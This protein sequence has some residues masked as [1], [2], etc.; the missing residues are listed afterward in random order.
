MQT[1]PIPLT[2]AEANHRR[3]NKEVVDQMHLH[4]ALD[5][6]LVDWLLDEYQGLQCPTT[7]DRWLR[8]G[9]T[10]AQLQ[11]SHP[12]WVIPPL[13][14]LPN[15]GIYQSFVP[16]TETAPRGSFEA[17]VRGW[18]ARF[19][20]EGLTWQDADDRRNDIR[21]TLHER[22]G[23][24]D[25]GTSVRWAAIARNHPDS[26]TSK[27]ARRERSV[28]K[29]VES[30]DAGY[31]L[32]CCAPREWADCV[33]LESWLSVAMDES[34]QQFAKSLTN[35]S[36]SAVLQNPRRR[37]LLAFF[38][39]TPG[40]TVGDFATQTGRDKTQVSAELRQ[41]LRAMVGKK[42]ADL[43]RHLRADRLLAALPTPVRDSLAQLVQS[44]PSAPT[45]ASVSA[46]TSAA[47]SA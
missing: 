38:M 33:T 12:A 35:S 39:N 16:P 20:G 5:P 4:L 21:Q 41:V 18:S 7:L 10:T 37:A 31:D 22:W 1:C 9:S 27:M 24:Y 25:A 36:L 13:P 3:Q 28:R 47:H 32:D 19:H 11:M 8:L 40:A 2:V 46:G 42:N 26:L 34:V 23:I 15:N 30:L 29:Q 14:S 43:L 6:D 44:S 17:F 45:L